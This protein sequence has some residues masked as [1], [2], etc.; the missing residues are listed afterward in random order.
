MLM[1]MAKTK[2][3]YIYKIHFLC[4]YPTGRYYLGK[5][6][7]Q[8]EDSYAGSGK[9][10]TA[11]YKKYGKVLGETYIK[12]IIEINPSKKINKKREKIIIGDLW[13]T[14]P[15][16]MN[17]KPG[18][19]GGA[20]PGHLTKNSTKRKIAEAI[21]NPIIQYDYRGNL[22]QEWATITDAANKYKIKA[23][24]ITECCQ[25]K[26]LLHKN[27][28]WRYQNNPLTT[29]E[30]KELNLPVISKF[31]LDGDFLESYCSIQYAALINNITVKNVSDC[32]LLNRRA[33]KGNTYR[34]SEDVKGLQYINVPTASKTGRKVNCYTKDGTYVK[35]Y[36]S[37]K[38][39]ARIVAKNEI[40]GYKNILYCCRGNKKS[41]YGYI[42]RYASDRITC[43]DNI[44]PNWESLK[45]PVMQFDL[46]G[47]YI[48]TFESASEASRQLGDK[49]RVGAI[50]ACANGKYNHAYGY[51]WKYV[52]E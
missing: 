41:A 6:T 2:I 1:I 15:L 31:N 8:I 20:I 44:V 39:A 34:F 26:R 3:H 30:I 36:S 24:Y 38:A 10:C 23:T 48:K 18:G 19:D 35:T 17:Q 51:R 29:A 13:K 46:D 50:A 49:C 7:G 25:G 42:W 16:C 47:N 28:I 52:N 45:K 11:Y 32:C 4:G 33:V 12:E 5:H 37:L 22:V 21:G 43:I 14:D 27:Y 40:T 9:F